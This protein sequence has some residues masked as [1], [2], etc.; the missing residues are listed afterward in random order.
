MRPNSWHGS[1][2]LNMNGLT[3]GLKSW[4]IY[5]NC[6]SQNAQKHDNNEDE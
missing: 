4:P 6:K 2:D 5:T 3:V 1:H